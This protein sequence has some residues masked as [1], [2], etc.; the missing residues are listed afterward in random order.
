LH[1]F[2]PRGANWLAHISQFELLPGYEEETFDQL[3]RE[4]DRAQSLGELDRRVPLMEILRILAGWAGRWEQAGT[5]LFPKLVE[6]WN[7]V[8][9]SL[10]DLVFDLFP[11]EY[12]VISS[13]PGPRFLTLQEIWGEAAVILFHRTS[14]FVA[15]AFLPTPAEIDVE[16]ANVNL[17][18][19]GPESDGDSS[20]V[21]SRGVR[22]GV[23]QNETGPL[24]QIIRGLT[25]VVPQDWEP[26]HIRAFLVGGRVARSQE[27]HASFTTALRERGIANEHISNEFANRRTESGGAVNLGL[28]RNTGRLAPFHPG[29]SSVDMNLRTRAARNRSLAETSRSEV[30]QSH[31]PLRRAE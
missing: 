3:A 5:P 10:Q 8:Q 22:S 15:A 19:S 11:G 21:A 24:T 1:H 26:I 23:E 20:R 27:L 16:S 7:P 18:S 14:T 2:L 12:T 28:D 4:L 29:F 13:L 30:E 9:V 17:R 6:L 31:L 25:A